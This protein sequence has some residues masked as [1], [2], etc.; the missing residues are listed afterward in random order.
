MLLIED[1]VVTEEGG[2]DLQRFDGVFPGIRLK[3]ERRAYRFPI[4]DATI[5]DAREVPVLSHFLLRG[6][7]ATA[8][9]RELMKTDTPTSPSELPEE[10]D[11]EPEP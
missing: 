11:E 9:L 2:L 4:R 6:R 10:P 8:V 1:A 3:R 7:N 5:G